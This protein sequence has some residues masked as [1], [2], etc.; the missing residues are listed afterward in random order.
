MKLYILDKDFNEEFSSVEDKEVQGSIKTTK[1]SYDVQYLSLYEGQY[2][3]ATFEG[4]SVRLHEIEVY[5]TGRLDLKLG[6][7]LCLVLFTLFVEV[8]GHEDLWHHG[9]ALQVDSS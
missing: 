3:L 8:Q 6:W 1:Y 4:V 5:P 7:Q 9:G 2:V